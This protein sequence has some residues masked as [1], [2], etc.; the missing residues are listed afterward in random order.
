MTLSALTNT[1]GETV[2]PTRWT[3]NTTASA[4]LHLIFY[5]LSRIFTLPL[6]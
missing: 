2:K 3:L 5:Q 6:R 1:F 4:I